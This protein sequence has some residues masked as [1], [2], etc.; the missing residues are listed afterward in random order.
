MAKT[1]HA[2]RP[3]RQAYTMTDEQ[4]AAMGGTPPPP[5]YDPEQTRTQK[6]HHPNGQVTMA[7]QHNPTDRGQPGKEA[8]LEVLQELAEAH[9]VRM[10]TIHWPDRHFPD[11]TAVPA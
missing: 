10:L 4:F 2:D 6:F 1:A 11:F 7:Y 9:G 8:P 5:G 3:P